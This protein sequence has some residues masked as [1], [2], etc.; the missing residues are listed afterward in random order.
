MFPHS[1]K[2]RNIERIDY[3][4]ERQSSRNEKSNEV[5]KILLSLHGV[6]AIVSFDLNGA[7]NANLK[8]NASDHHQ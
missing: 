7:I 3:R 8:D 1:P 5:A 2:I 6:V 4:S